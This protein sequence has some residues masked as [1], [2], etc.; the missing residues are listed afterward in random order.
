MFFSEVMDSLERGIEDKLQCHNLILEINSSRYAYNVSLKEVNYF[1]CKAILS[2]PFQL[3]DGSQYLQALSRC[4]AYFSPILKN[5]IRDDDS[6]NDCLQAVQDVAI[7]NNELSSCIVKVLNWLYDK[8]FLSEDV[9]S[10]WFSNLDNSVSIYSKVVP[11][12]KWL[13]E[14]E[15]ETSDDEDD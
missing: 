8:D 13:Q 11:F 14:A 1:V 2:L 4:L 15:E 6:M 5:Y 12:V 7:A 3:Q 10:S 9:I